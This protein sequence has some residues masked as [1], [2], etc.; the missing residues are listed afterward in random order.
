MAVPFVDTQ[1]AVR[2]LDSDGV[3]VMDTDTLPGFHCRADRSAAIARIQAL[4]GRDSGKPLL[5]VAGSAE[6]AARVTAD[7]SAGQ[8]EL[9]AACWPGP[10]SI[11]LPADP[12]LDPRV[13]GG[14]GTVAVR[15]PASDRLRDLVL[16]AGYPLVSK[17]ANGAGD[18]PA[19]RLEEAVRRFPD[20]VDGA[21]G[22]ADAGES[23]ALPGPS[24]LVDAT[25]LP[26]RVLRE[27]PLPLPGSDEPS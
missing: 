21:W 20:A 22:I 17:S 19:T 8:K 2:I 26:P 23:N 1:H 3:L 15:V 6:Q 10:F 4:K 16:A 9:L 18:P 14:G 11:I 25:V 7:L 24:A 13:T 27:G 5:V 12:G